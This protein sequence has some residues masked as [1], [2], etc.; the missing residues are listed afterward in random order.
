LLEASRARLGRPHKHHPRVPKIENEA[1][2]PL[3]VRLLADAGDSDHGELEKQSKTAPHAH[4]DA[5][6]KP[7]PRTRNLART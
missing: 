3:K 2:V 7:R 5:H 4:A 1:R 6:A